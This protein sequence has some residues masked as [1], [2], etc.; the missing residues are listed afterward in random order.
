MRKNS[1]LKLF[2]TLI[3]F[4]TV[5]MDAQN[6]I[7]KFDTNTISLINLPKLKL[8]FGKNKNIPKAYETQILIALSYFPELKNATIA[9]VLKKANT[10]LSARPS[11][12]GLFQSAKN[13]KYTITISEE[14]NSKL[15]PIL[16]K[17]L[18]LNAQIGVLG[19][20]LS[21]VSDYMEKGFGKMSTLIWIEIFSKKEVDIFEYK[22]DLRCINH[23][24]G[25]Q[26][27]E[28]SKSVR[29]NLK[30]DYWRGAD[31]LRY[32]SKKERYLNPETI[33]KIMN[34]N[35]LYGNGINLSVE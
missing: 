14:T 29:V 27:L 25:Y 13:R 18:N 21:H 23:G 33:I 1:N 30:I 19:H 31:N 20:E 34:S 11:F 24:L 28:W 8:E 16:F 5:S 35:A 10:P 17:N 12:I 6:S 32:P 22:T 2:L 26:L 7:K 3:F 15:E 4:L 9:F